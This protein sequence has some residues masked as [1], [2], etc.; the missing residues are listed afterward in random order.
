MGTTSGKTTIVAFMI[1]TDAGERLRDMI[2]DG[3][4]VEATL[5]KTLK[6]A[7]PRDYL[8]DVISGFSSR[9]P[10]RNDTF[11]PNIA[12]IGSQI[13]APLMGGG[14]RGTK[15][16]GTSM[17]GPHVSGSAVLLRAVHPDWTPMQVRSSMNL[18]SKIEGLIRADGSL[19]DAWDL[20]SGRID[21]TRAALTGI[22]L[23]ET[24]A[25]FVAANPGAGGDM[26][27]LNLASM[28]S[29]NCATTCTFT[30][31]LTSTQLL[32]EDYVLTIDGLPTGSM[33]SKSSSLGGFT[34]TRPE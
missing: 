24:D 2:I 20:G 23:D 3:V 21:L 13:N 14:D 18:T 10:G 19:V 29:A 34:W 25:N 31:T 22:V 17:S 11:K 15:L 7:F 9:G 26:S 27:T 28:A 33:P 5:S 30:R 8:A 16:D 32:D 12:G 4:P 6:G 1:Q